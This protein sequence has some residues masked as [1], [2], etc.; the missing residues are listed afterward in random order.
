MTDPSGNVA[1]RHRYEPYGA[2]IGTPAFD[3]VFRFA[4][5]MYSTSLEYYK[6]GMRWYDPE[7]RAV[8]AA[9]LH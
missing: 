8:D 9:G 3:S 6:M 5:Q 1:G 4:G 2:E 7:A